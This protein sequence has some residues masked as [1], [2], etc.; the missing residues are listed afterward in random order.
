MCFALVLGL[1]LTATG[2]GDPNERAIGRALGYF[3]HSVS[4]A[5]A[6]WAGL[7]GYMHRRFGLV[8]TD[9]GGKPL[10]ATATTDPN[11]LDE[12]R[13]YRRLDDPQAAVSVL[14]IEAMPSMIDRMTAA[15]LHCDRIPLPSNWLAVL[16]RATEVGGYALT[17]AALAGQWTI[18]NGCRDWSALTGLQRTQIDALVALAG[19]PDRLIAEFDTPID[20]RLESMAML[21]YLGAAGRIPHQWIEEVRASQ[22]SDGGWPLHPALDQSDPHPT[23]LAL[24]V[25]LERRIPATERIRW[26]AAPP[27]YVPTPI[28]LPEK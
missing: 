4:E 15:A 27:G 10:H 23:A 17:H 16:S 13:I 20:L 5:D 2:C 3:E 28:N 22:R 1:M 7:F 14:D 8:A 24:W 26:I 19:S 9:A 12:S 18:E 21:G 11:D 25:L 6:S